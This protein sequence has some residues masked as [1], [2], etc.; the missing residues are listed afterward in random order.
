MRDNEEAVPFEALADVDLIVDQLYDGGRSGSVTDDPLAQMLPIGNQG[1]FRYKGSPQKRAVRLAVLYTTGAEPDWPDA[2]DPQTGLF[3]YYGDNRR[4]GHELH[5]TRRSGNL[6][7]RDCFDWSHQSAEARRSVPPFLLFEKAAPGR[8]IMFRGLLAPGGPGLSSDD[9]LQAIWRSTDGRRFQNYRARFTV[10]DV[11]R[12]ER[13]WLVDVLTGNATSS[14]HCPS[15]WTV[16]GDGRKYT[17]M[18]A[19]PTTVTRN[20]VEQL[21]TDPD[22]RA[23]LAEIHKKFSGSAHDF[24][25]CAVELWRLIAPATGRCDVTQPSRDGG[26]DAVGEYVVGPA[27]DPIV[28]DFALEAKCYAETNSV[29]VRDVARLIS[30]LRHRQFGVFVTTSYFNQQVYS[31]VRSDVHPI[32]LISGRDIVDALRAAGHSGMASVQAWLRQ[33]DA[34]NQ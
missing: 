22:G 18:L 26:R 1:G 28:I 12:I 4:P 2:L 16:W 23:I 8:R 15:A 6:L 19:P 21:P 3:T 27:S 20:R 25:R 5:D 9:E 10:L 29:G 17:P 33:F 34:T 7:L 30:R 11:P 13:K 24:E 14:P 31:E 32:V